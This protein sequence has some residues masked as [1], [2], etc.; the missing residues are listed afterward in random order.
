MLQG[1]VKPLD[2]RFSLFQ[3]YFIQEDSSYE[4][5]AKSDFNDIVKAVY[6][7]RDEGK[8]DGKKGFH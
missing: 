4:D 7:G 3:Y 2:M 6:E 1:I 5:S 8:P